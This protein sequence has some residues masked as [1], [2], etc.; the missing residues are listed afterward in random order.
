M[1]LASVVREVIHR[2]IP[3]EGALKVKAAPLLR[4]RD[5]LHSTARCRLSKATP[6]EEALLRTNPRVEE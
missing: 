1:M 3:D 4:N 2:N 6:T 5:A